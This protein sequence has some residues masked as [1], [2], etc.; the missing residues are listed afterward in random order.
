MNEQTDEMNKNIAIIRFCNE[1]DV[2]APLVHAE[3]KA[4]GWWNDPISGQ[5]FIEN[6]LFP[7]VVATKMMLIV[8]ETVEAMEGYRRDTMDD[9]LPNREMVEVELA[10]V[11]IRILDLAGALGLAVG[12]ALV[13]KR[14][15]NATREDHKVENRLQQGGKKF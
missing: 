10:D 3:N 15:F 9:K 5:P 11:I 4:A 7:Y 14:T 13:E 1:L 8:S 6:D 12:A 2:V